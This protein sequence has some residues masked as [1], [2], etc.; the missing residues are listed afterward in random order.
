MTE[1]AQARRGSADELVGETLTVSRI[2]GSKR[3][4]TLRRER[5]PGY[6]LGTLTEARHNFGTLTGLIFEWDRNE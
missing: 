4:E 1:V 6:F 3:P 2:D 5:P